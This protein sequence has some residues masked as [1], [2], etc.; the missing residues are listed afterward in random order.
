[1]NGPEY[2]GV[3]AHWGVYFAVDDCDATV[4]KA[5][6]MGATSC[7]PPTDIP[8]VGRFAVIQDPQ[9]AI[10]SVFKGLQPM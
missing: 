8:N 6:G 1:M 5:K 2:Q 9:G 4:E 3:P 7:V 10:F